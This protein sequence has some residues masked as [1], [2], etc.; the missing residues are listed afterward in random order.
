[1]NKTLSLASPHPSGR[2]PGG[3][4]LNPLRPNGR[5]YPLTAPAI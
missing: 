2:P 3:G 1:M 5:D 4:D